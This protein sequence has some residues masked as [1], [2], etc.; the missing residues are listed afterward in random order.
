MYF[1]LIRPLSSGQK[2]VQKVTNYTHITILH[3]LTLGCISIVLLVQFGTFCIDFCQ[4]N[5][6]LIRTKHVLVTINF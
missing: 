1:D 4:L 3:I 2:S 6:G 5:N